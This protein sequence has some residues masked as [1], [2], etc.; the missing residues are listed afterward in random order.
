LNNRAKNLHHL[1]LLKKEEGKTILTDTLLY[2]D[3][4]I[5]TVINKKTA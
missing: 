3:F 4:A 2:K 5:K 1:L